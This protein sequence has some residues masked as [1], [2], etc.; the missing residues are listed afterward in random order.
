MSIFDEAEQIVN[1][2][3][4]AEYGPVRESFQAIGDVWTG[5]LAAAGVITNQEAHVR[6]ED[7]ALC[8]LGLKLVRYAHGQGRDSMVDM[9]GYARCLEL[10]Q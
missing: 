4:H 6:A 1:G 10:M 9:A 7:V 3:R 8:M 5:I 2:P